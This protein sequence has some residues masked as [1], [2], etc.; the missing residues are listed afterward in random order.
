MEK[1]VY[2]KLLQVQDQILLVAFDKQCKLAD[3][4]STKE[5]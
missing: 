2:D 4:Y 3:Q 5:N 1:K